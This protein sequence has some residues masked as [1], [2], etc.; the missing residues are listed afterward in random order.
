[1]RNAYMVQIIV[2]SAADFEAAAIRQ[3]GLQVVPLKTIFSD[4]EF[5]EGR[6]ISR[7]DFYRKMEE[8]GEI[9]RTSQASPAE[10]EAVYRQ[11]TANGDTAVVITV[12]GELSGTFQSAAIAAEG[13]EEAIFV[14]DSRSATIGEQILAIRACI[15]RDEGCSA[16]EITA[17]LE[18]EKRKI[19]LFGAVDS[20]EHLHKGGRLSK[21]ATVVGGL[22]GI[23]PVLGI[24]DGA[25][26]QL[27]KARGSRQSNNL[28]VQ[29]IENHGGVDFSRPLMAAHSGNDDRL[30]CQYIE[31]SRRLWETELDALPRGTIGCAIGSHLG[32][33]AILVAFFRK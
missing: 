8:T 29:Q 19:C 11:V 16:R 20:L 26:V 7:A 4:G 3:Y 14:I 13:M 9:P 21:T 27:G 22:L 28:L 6:D 12:S 15:L 24:V 31:D 10:F 32:P 2:D 33:T 30:L 18:E 5:V 17:R 25:I 23:K 1:M